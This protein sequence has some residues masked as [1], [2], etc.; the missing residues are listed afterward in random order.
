MFKTEK[1]PQEMEPVVSNAIPAL[2]YLFSLFMV[3]FPLYAV[4]TSLYAVTFSLYSVPIVRYGNYIWSIFP[5]GT[6]QSNDL[7]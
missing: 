1:L 7:T 5:Y 3:A 2:W 4:V 6:A